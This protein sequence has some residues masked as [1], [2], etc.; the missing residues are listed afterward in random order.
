LRKLRH[1]LRCHRVATL[2]IA[3][4][5]CSTV[6]IDELFGP[7]M[8]ASLPMYDLPEIRDA[9]DGFW[10]AVARA[11]GVQGELTRSSDWV[12]PWRSPDLLFSQTCGY[13]MTHQ[14]KDVFTYVATPHYA[15]D[16][17]KGPNYCSILLARHFAELPS[18]RGKVAAFNSRDSMSGMLALQ[19]MFA[20]HA[21]QGQFFDRSIQTSG[22]FASLQAVQRGKADICAIDCVTVAYARRYRPAVMDG[23]V[24]IARSP[25]VPGLP[26]ITRSGDVARLRQALD[27]VLHDSRHNDIC[28]ALLLTGISTC[29]ADY[30]VIPKLER[31]MQSAGGLR[32]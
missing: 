32:L 7:I 5:I 4:L 30:D 10:A 13:P 26:Y 24:E 17:C 27:A 23:L 14:F 15:A 29:A 20:P 2:Y 3:S 18:F 21:L 16:G 8:L 31:A 25:Q 6:T 9:T 12:E 22:H 1:K 11:Y 19:V 28:K